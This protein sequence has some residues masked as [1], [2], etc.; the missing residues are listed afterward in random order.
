MTEAPIISVKNPEGSRASEV[1]FS[2]AGITES[3]ETLGGPVSDKR[4]G[5]LVQKESSLVYEEL[6]EVW[7]KS[8]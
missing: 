5:D 6:T 3:S 1:P 7:W 8:I 4:G 2:I